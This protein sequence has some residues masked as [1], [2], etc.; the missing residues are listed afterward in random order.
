M[1]NAKINQLKIRLKGLMSHLFTEEDSIF[2]LKTALKV[3]GIGLFNLFFIFFTIYSL[4]KVNSIFFEAHGYSSAQ[5]LRSAYYQ[6]VLSASL[7]YLPWLLLFFVMLFFA[8]VYVANKLLRPFNGISNYCEKALESENASYDID[9]FSDFKL[10]T[11]FSEYFFS[12]VNLCRE[13]KKLRKHSIPPQYTKIHGPVFDRVFFFHFLLLISIIC[14][15]TLV[16]MNIITSEIY[17]GLIEL[18][19]QTLKTKDHPTRQFLL[20]QAGLFDMI[21]WLS[22]LTTSVL[23]LLLSAH[24]YSLVSGAAFGVF[25]TMRSFMKGNYSARVHLLGYTYVRPFTR[26]F[27]KFLDYLQR[28]YPSE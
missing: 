6:F 10:L 15:F 26:N 16:V 21:T 28:N 27:N 7:E 12:Y 18:A 19:I 17:E 24:L 22:M 3:V 20:G 2:V 5:E 11:R 23:Y 25:A 8:G 13:E 9:S 1:E 14:I 4:L